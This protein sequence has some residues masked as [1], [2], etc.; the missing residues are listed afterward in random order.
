MTRR[1]KR[2]AP[3]TKTP[4]AFLHNAE[5]WPGNGRTSGMRCVIARAGHARDGGFCDF[6][7][8]SCSLSHLDLTAA[9]NT[10]LNT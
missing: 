2:P 1:G 5:R 8:G 9:R 3:W 10:S 7:I 4:G 6:P